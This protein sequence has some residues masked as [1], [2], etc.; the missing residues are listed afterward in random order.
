MAKPDL[1]ITAEN[2]IKNHGPNA[3]MEAAMIADRMEKRG[4]VEGHQAWVRITNA[5]RELERAPHH[6]N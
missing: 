4:D 5:I 6:A 2:L 1:W 3:A